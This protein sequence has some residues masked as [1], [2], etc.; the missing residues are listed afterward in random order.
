MLAIK[1]RFF[2]HKQTQADW[3][4]Y[5]HVIHKIHLTEKKQPTTIGSI[6]KGGYKLHNSSKQ[7]TK[8]SAI[9]ISAGRTIR[10]RLVQQLQAP[11]L[12]IWQ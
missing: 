5:Q 9:P 12:L 4:R 11:V 6:E 7:L 1:C 8:I 3:K 2:I 10:W